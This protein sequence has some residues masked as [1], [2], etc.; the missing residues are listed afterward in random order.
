MGIGVGITTYSEN[1]AA[2]SIT[3]V[4]SRH[5]MQIAGIIL[6]LLGV[7]TKVGAVLATIPDPM[8]GGILGM[9]VCMITGVALSNLEYVNI[10]LSRNLT[11]MGIAIIMG[12]VIP[13]YFKSHPVDTGVSDIDQML[14]ILLTIQMFVGGMIAFILDNT[15]SGATR[16]ER[17]FQP[18][19]ILP[20]DK[21]IDND[22]DPDGYAFPQ[23]VNEFLIKYSGF[24]KFPFM[25]SMKR[26]EATSMPSLNDPNSPH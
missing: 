24:C 20:V 18:N 15:C 11:I 19:I 7:F 2:V 14:N 13:D 26:L 25:P 22:V 9:G 21:D 23:K 17:G 8:V 3:R 4:A 6:V 12:V 10:K 16:D 1:V 5:T